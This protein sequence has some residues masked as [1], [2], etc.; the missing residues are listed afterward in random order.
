MLCARAIYLDSA[1]PALAPSQVFKDI[2]SCSGASSQERKKGHV[3]KLLAASKGNE[4]GYVM[5][6]LQVRKGHSKVQPAPVNM[7]V[8]A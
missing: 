1:D 5:R 3:I 2:A 6:S 8:L 4:A 7:E